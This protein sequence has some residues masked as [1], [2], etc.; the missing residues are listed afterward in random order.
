MTRRDLNI[1]V[2]RTLL[3]AA[4]LVV[5]NAQPE[6]LEKDLT[7]IADRVFASQ[8]LRLS[9]NSRR[10]F[11]KFIDDG[12]VDMGYGETDPESVTKAKASAAIFA[13]EIGPH[14]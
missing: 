6:N 8:T 2:A 12:V 14:H 11:E 7:D 3:F 5:G 1:Y 13:E 4:S 9:E 10:S